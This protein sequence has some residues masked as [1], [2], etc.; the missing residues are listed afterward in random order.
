MKNEFKA[1]FL[2]FIDQQ[3]LLEEDDIVVIAYSGGVDSSVL[4]HLM[5]ELKD[6]L[7]VNLIIAY[8]N[9]KLRGLESG[10]EERFVKEKAK[11]LRLPL[12][13][14]ATD[15]KKTAG[16]RSWSIQQSARHHRYEFF[17]KVSRK[18]DSCKIATAHHMDD[19]AET[20]LMN[21]LKGSGFKG[22][23]GIPVKRDNFI[24]PLLWARRS[25]IEQYAKESRISY[26]ED[27]SNCKSGYLRNRIRHRIIPY[28]EEELETNLSKILVDQ[29][30]RFADTYDWI[31]EL[32]NQS[33][34]AV[35]KHKT[36]DKIVLDITIFRTYF[37]MLQKCVLNECMR[38]MGETNEPFITRTTNRIFDF[39]NATFKPKSLYISSELHV[40]VD[41]KSLTVSRIRKNV[42]NHNVR[43]GDRYT[44]D[45]EQFRFYSSTIAVRGLKVSEAIDELKANKWDEVIDQSKITGNLVLRNWEPGDKFLPLGMRN[46]KKLSDYFIDAKIPVYNKNSSPLLVDEEKIV[47]ICGH[48]IDERV[49]I[50]GDTKEAVGLKYINFA[51]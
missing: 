8:F 27:S 22:M 43:I 11:E 33:L 37:S 48:R 49:K 16:I 38:K 23:R 15:I 3:S 7:K 17:E 19:Q 36:K 44:F 32:T 45:D 21:V 42:Y 24:R 14:C 13:T 4:L 6:E 31:N 20:V 30:N 46:S 39:V 25:E 40:I 41:K 51:L 18:H 9:H 26:F 1:G 28:I 47:W 35:I 10:R 34:E 5:S 50:T 2:E 29:G 12:E